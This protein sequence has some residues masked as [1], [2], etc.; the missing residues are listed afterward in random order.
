MNDN[1]QNKKFLFQATSKWAMVLGNPRKGYLD[2]GDEWSIDLYLSPEE[3]ARL[4]K[5]GIGAHFIKDRGE[6]EYIKL[7][8]KAVKRNG[9]VN[10]PIRVVDHHNEPWP[11]DRLI[12]NGSVVNVSV[13]LHETSNPS[14]PK[15]K[16]LKPNILSLQV[17]DWKEY[18]PDP[19]KPKPGEFPVK[20]VPGGKPGDVPKWERTEDSEAA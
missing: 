18:K 13:A 12:G 11:Q 15:E 8:R 10:P 7:I 20:A 9:E 3:K 16:Y 4:L 5:A 14:K 6:G 2:S 19:N 1:T 17:W